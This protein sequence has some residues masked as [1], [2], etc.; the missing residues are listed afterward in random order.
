MV[1]HVCR[2]DI[3]VQAPQGVPDEED[4]L[5][6]AEVQAAGDLTRPIPS[7]ILLHGKALM[8]MPALPLIKI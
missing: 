5:L 3:V 4:H 2:E 6:L 1:W 7:V 8:A